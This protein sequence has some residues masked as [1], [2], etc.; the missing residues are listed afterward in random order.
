V[1]LRVSRAP[2]GK[3]TVGAHLEKLPDA[4]VREEMRG[5]WRAALDRLLADAQ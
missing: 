1:Q 5:H 3:T 4:E 2:S